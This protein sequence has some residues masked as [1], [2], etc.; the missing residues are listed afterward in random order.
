MIASAQCSQASLQPLRIFQLAIASKGFQIKSFR[1]SLPDIHAGRNKVRR[2]V[3]L[4][5]IDG[6]LTKF[7]RIHATSDVDANHVGHGLSR[8]RHGRSDRAALSRVHVRHDADFGPLREGVIT[9]PADLL[10]CFVLYY[11][12]VADCRIY[13]SLNFKHFFLT[14]QKKTAYPVPKQDKR[15]TIFSDS[16]PD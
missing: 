16:S 3:H 1:P 2:L 6:S 11:C 7:H 8:N 5:K 15:L 13:F 10:Y 4:F 14:S 12:R 9:H